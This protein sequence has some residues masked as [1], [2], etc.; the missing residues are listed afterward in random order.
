MFSRYENCK[1]IILYGIGT[2]FKQTNMD[3]LRK[4]A[5][6]GILAIET[7]NTSPLTLFVHVMVQILLHN[8]LVTALICAIHHFELT[9]HLVA[10]FTTK[11]TKA[12]A[13]IALLKQQCNYAGKNIIVVCRTMILNATVLQS[14]QRFVQNSKI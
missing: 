6:V 5:D 7:K 13:T 11:T 10:L 12:Q 9:C 2:I 8:F 14:P 3:Y 4:S 1:T